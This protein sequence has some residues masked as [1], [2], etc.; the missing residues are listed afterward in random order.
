MC[1]KEGNDRIDQILPPTHHVAIQVFLV[2]VISLVGDDAAHAEEIH[3]L[4]ETRDA[5]CALCHSKLMCHLIAVFIAFST[6]SVMLP[7]KADGEA[8]LS[9]YKTNNPTSLKQPFLLI[10][11]THHIVTIPS[12]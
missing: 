12:A 8:T 5:L 4:S 3:E 11:C 9:V 2:V 10:F 6:R 1:C 7:N